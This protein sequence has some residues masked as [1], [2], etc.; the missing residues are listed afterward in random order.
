MSCRALSSPGDAF[1]ARFLA[2]VPREVAASFTPAQLQAVQRAFGMR[3]AV[4]HAVDL[5]RTWRL[6][7]GR[8]YLVLLAGRDRRP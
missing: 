8:F 2:R 5:R 4:E 7:W 3:Y 1:I 6:P